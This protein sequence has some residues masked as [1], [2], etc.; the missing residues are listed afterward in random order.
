MEIGIVMLLWIAAALLFVL[1]SL[2]IYLVIRKIIL[3]GRHRKTDELTEKYRQPFYDYLLKGNES[4]LLLP[5]RDK[6]KTEALVQ[7]LMQCA[8]LFRGDDSLNRIRAYAERY[9]S[10]RDREQLGRRSWNRRMQAL[11]RIERFDMRA[12]EP[13]LLEMAKRRRTS[14][15][16]R[17]ILLKLLA[18]WASSSAIDLIAATGTTLP[19]FQRRL[20]L[21]QMEPD[22]FS[23]F[24]HRWNDLPSSWQH[25]AI[26]TI[27]IRRAVEHRAMLDELAVSDDGEIRIRSLKALCQLGYAP[28]SPRYLVHAESADWQERLMA[29]KLY[30]VIRSREHGAALASLIGDPNWFVRSQAAQSLLVYEEGARSLRKIA[31]ASEDRFAREMAKE[32]LERGGA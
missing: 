8:V 10:S 9:L 15:E 11:H 21:S 30:G 18:R 28:P 6:R 22:T 17:T 25:T 32:W 12:M 3:N 1:V 7:L 20:I 26:D 16:E 31:A 2:F 27:G 19:D 29:A 4:R 14:E 5:D 24:I 13:T 23:A